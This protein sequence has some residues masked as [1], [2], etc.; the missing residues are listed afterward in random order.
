MSIVRR[1]HRSAGGSSDGDETGIVCIGRAFYAI[2][3]R[4]ENVESLDECWVAI[5]K[6]GYTLDDTR[7]IDTVQNQDQ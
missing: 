4:E 6:M 3:D 7:G 2:S 1:L 5:K